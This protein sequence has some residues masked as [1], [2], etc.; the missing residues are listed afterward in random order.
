MRKEAEERANA[1]DEN[2]GTG[3]ADY[4]DDFQALQSSG[5][6]RAIS[7]ILTSVSA[8]PEVYPQLEQILLPIILR[9]EIDIDLFEELLEIVGYIT[10]YSPQIS[11]EMWQVWPKMLAVLDNGWALQYFEHVLIPM[12]NFISRNTDIFVSSAKRKRIHTSSAK[13]GVNSRRGHGR[14]H[15]DCTKVDGMRF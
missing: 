2:E 7:T 3:N 12:D 9:M 4:D 13:E 14:R 11:Q 5:C 8:L 15:D 10:Y 6:L 1:E